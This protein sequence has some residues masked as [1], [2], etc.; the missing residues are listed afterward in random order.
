MGYFLDKFKSVPA[1]HIILLADQKNTHWANKLSYYVQTILICMQLLTHS[2]LT[3]KQ[4]QV[5]YPLMCLIKRNKHFRSSFLSLSSLAW[6]FILF[7][8]HWSFS[9]NLGNVSLLT[10]VARVLYVIVLVFISRRM[11]FMCYCTF[12]FLS[13]YL[14]VDHIQCCTITVTLAP[15]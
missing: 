10:A 13:S 14:T 4:A 8:A 2:D 1:P 5:L 12:W 3:G 15:S 7:T 11:L 6:L 9:N